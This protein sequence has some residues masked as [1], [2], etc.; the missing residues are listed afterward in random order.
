LDRAAG[1][2]IARARTLDNE[3]AGDDER[4]GNGRDEIIGDSMIAAGDSADGD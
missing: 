3:V 2:V 4:D 1:E